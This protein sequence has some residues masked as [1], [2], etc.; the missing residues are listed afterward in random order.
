MSIF[1][2][3]LLAIIFFNTL[4]AVITVFRKPRDIAATWAWLLVLILLPIFGFLLYSFTGRGM[5]RQKIYH[6]QG[7]DRVGLEQL[8][9]MQQHDNVGMKRQDSDSITDSANQLIQLFRTLDKAPLTRRNHIDLFTDGET[10][11]KKMFAEIDQATES[12]HVEFYTIYPDEL[13]TQFLHLIEKK[14]QQGVQV[15]VLY[16]AFGS[17]GTT[18]KWF[19]KFES[20]GGQ[21][22]TF[23]TSHNSLTKSRL[24]YHD[25]R[26][27]VVIDG[28]IGY[29]GGFNIGDQY[30]GRKKK[31]GYWRDTH[32]RMVGTGVLALQMHFMMDWNAS[33]RPQEE[34]HYQAQYFPHP[35]KIKDAT[36]N[37]QVVT[38]GPVAGVL[39]IRD[40]YI[41]MISM[42]KRSIW[43]QSP[44]LVPDESV[45]SALCIAA[46]AGV[47]VRIMIPDMPDHPFIYRATQYYAQILF[48]RGVHIY[49]YQNGFIHAKTVVM[50]DQIVS[51]GSA[52]Q[53][54][55]SYK[56]NFEINT[57]MYDR[58]IARKQTHIF[59]KDMFYSRE[60]TQEDIDNQSE[61]LRF[62]QRFSRLLS[63]VL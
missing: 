50:D 32:L 12:V 47:D 52:N 10:L 60:L 20:Y 56:L 29:T 59:E 54:I 2:W 3:I 43:I 24:N 39:P 23:V 4:A 19:K 18:K 7:Q 31:F 14:A 36:T 46:S 41:R 37:L 6:I 33:V 5:G 11:F 26:K 40:G 28:K 42:A 17:H 53:D 21:D 22:A 15:R 58:K 1:N 30:V 34:V 62:K 35:P 38:S 8:F 9:E 57:F 27:N 51:I 44:Y 63:P 16:D 55:R 13:G 49:I 25:H 48:G 61:W 45:L